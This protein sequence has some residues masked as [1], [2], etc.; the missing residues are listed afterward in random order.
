M[1][2]ESQP[3]PPADDALS[4][5]LVVEDEL[6]AN[7]LV[8]MLSRSQGTTFAITRVLRVEEA[9]LRKGDLNFG[10]QGL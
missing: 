6:T 3:V 4:L 10:Q 9:L 2:E 7:R 8:E 5:L 1:S